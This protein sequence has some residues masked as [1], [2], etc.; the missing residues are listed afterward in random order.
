M[1]EIKFLPV[2]G[3]F[4]LLFFFSCGTNNEQA[5]DDSEIRY[6]YY[7]LEHAG[8]KSKT[9]TQKAD[10]ISFNATEVPIEYYILKEM[11]KDDLFETDS[12]Y[13]ENKKERI[14]EFQF[15]QDKEKDL[16][17]KEFTGKDYQESVKY[18]SFNIEKD[19]YV[20]TSKNDTIACSGVTFE[21]NFKVAPYQKLLLFFTGIPPE[22]EIQLIYQDRLFNKGTLKFKFNE[23]TTKL[24]L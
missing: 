8:W 13:Q 12:V 22:D 21:R 6:R 19:F 16:L 17:A 20:V 2:I 15:S 5:K 23:K 18:M 3:Y 10:D 7:E 14:V 1:K 4:S 9:H 11:G 24:L